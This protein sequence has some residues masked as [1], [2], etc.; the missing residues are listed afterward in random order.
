MHRVTWRPQHRSPLSRRE[1]GI[2]VRSLIRCNYTIVP[3][4]AWLAVQLF[5]REKGR[6]LVPADLCHADVR[7]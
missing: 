2:N 3:V 7:L 6:K 1:G 4:K 5:K